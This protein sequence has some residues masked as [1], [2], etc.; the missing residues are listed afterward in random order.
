MSKDIYIDLYEND[1][2]KS[3]RF[4]FIL[5]IISIMVLLFIN[6]DYSKTIPVYLINEDS[7]YIIGTNNN[8]ILNILESKLY[9]DGVEYKFQ[10]VDIFSDVDF[11]EMKIKIEKFEN[12]NEIINGY[13][14]TK[15]VKIKEIIKTKIK[16]AI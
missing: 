11:S 9:I 4:I 13:F 2:I 6:L 1:Y 15:K 10:I 7:Y 16:E 14:K 8:D 3:S 12:N 5:I